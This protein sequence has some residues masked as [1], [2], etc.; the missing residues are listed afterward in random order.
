MDNTAKIQKLKNEIA[1]KQKEL[2]VIEHLEEL[3]TTARLITTTNCAF[4]TCADCP[5]NGKNNECLSL[6]IKE[7]LDKLS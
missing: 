6:V 5:F 1:E 2:M 7:N 3:I 4:V